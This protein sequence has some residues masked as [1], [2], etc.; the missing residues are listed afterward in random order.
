MTSKQNELVIP[1]LIIEIVSSSASETSE[2][3]NYICEPCGKSFSHNSQYKQH[4]QSQNH[5]K[6]AKKNEMRIANANMKKKYDGGKL[7]TTLDSTS[8]CLFCNCISDSFDQ[9]IVHMNEKHGFFLPCS[10]ALKDK[11]SVLKYLAEKIHIGNICIGCNNY[12]TGNFKNSQGV[13]QHMKDKGH[14]YLELSIFQEEYG[15]FI[16]HRDQFLKKRQPISSRISAVMSMKEIEEV[17]KKNESENN[18]NNEDNGETDNKSESKS[19]SFACVSAV[20]SQD[21]IS[22]NS[23]NSVGPENEN[24]NENKEDHKEEE[25]E[26]IQLN[27]VA[28][29]EDQEKPPELMKSSSLS[30]SETSSVSEVSIAD[31]HILLDTGELL[32]SNGKLI[33]HRMYNYIYKQR[34]PTTKHKELIA[35]NQKRMKEIKKLSKGKIGGFNTKASVPVHI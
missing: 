20:D 24:E 11:E 6:K 14:T 8:I 13:Q 17:K 33:G 15:T 12:R 7:K 22:M 25:W 32:L 35:E 19:S 26:D 18:N 27:D 4:L 3:P 5:I 9:N 29:P 30:M 2:E 16:K 21:V 28:E 31:E 1:M 23:S 10:E 34:L